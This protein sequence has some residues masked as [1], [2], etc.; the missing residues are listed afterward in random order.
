MTYGN[1]TRTTSTYDRQTFR[2]QTLTT[3]KGP[4]V[5]QDLGYTFDV[6]GNVTGITDPRHG[7]QT[8]RYD[9]LDRLTQA[10]NGATGGY[11]TIT[12]S[13]NEI[14]NLLSHSKVGTYSYN[15]SGASSVRPH[16]VASTSLTTG[17]GADAKTTTTPYSY[18]ANGNLVSGGGRT[19]TWDAENQPTQIVKD[20]VTTTFVHDGDG[21]RVKKTVRTP[22]V[23]AETGER[24]TSEVTTVYIGNLLVCQG[25]ACARL[26]YAGDQ[27]VALVQM[28]SGATSYFHGDHLDS[29]AVLTDG[30]GNAEEHNSYRPYGKLQT[31]TGS[32]DVAYKYTGQEHDASTGLVFYLARFYDL[33]VGRFVSPDTYVPDPLDPQALN[34]YAYALNNPLR[35]NDPTGHC[36]S[37]C[38]G[39]GPSGGQPGD[40][41]PSEPVPV[42]EE[43]LVTAPP[44][45]P[46]PPSAPPRRIIIAPVVVP[47]DPDP[48]SGVPDFPPVPFVTPVGGNMSPILPADQFE[49]LEEG[50]CVNQGCN[51]D[52][53]VGPTPAQ[54]HPKVLVDPYWVEIK[55]RRNAPIAGGVAVRG[56]SSLDDGTVVS[57]EMYR[58][59]SNQEL[60]P[61]FSFLGSVKG[62]HPSHF[63]FT[64]LDVGG[65][66]HGTQLLTVYYGDVKFY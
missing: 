2:L 55:V 45:P 54:I 1:G 22:Q 39:C 56:W 52:I 31:H 61:P 42:L 16:A 19:L 64:V 32:S 24:S 40:A 49:L 33:L 28:T 37:G 58:I 35:Y 13:Y 50:F 48:P 21:G 6:G 17:S 46:A 8:F 30:K 3:Q 9:A 62:N 23:D 7:T 15:A 34:R 27:R 65:T 66:S 44:L 47:P 26:I 5:L 11:G 12:Y 43:V 60:A 25:Q 38:G 51:L 53:T 59:P 4:T 14:G 29:T 63:L 10:T 18:D 57:L 41:A 20:G 36:S